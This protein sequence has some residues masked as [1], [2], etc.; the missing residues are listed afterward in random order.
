MAYRVALVQA[1]GRRDL[2]FNRNQGDDSDLFPGSKGVTQVDGASGTFPNLRKNDGTPTG[3]ALTGI[4]EK[5]GVV[6]VSVK[7]SKLTPATS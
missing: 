1:D 7:F 3:I 4:A 6:D 2:E 5:G